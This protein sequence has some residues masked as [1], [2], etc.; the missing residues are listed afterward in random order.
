MR[1][2]WMIRVISMT[3]LIRH[4]ATGPA[5]IEVG[6]QTIAVCQCGLSRNKPFCDG[7]H[8]KT[9]GE[10]HGKLYIY[11]AAQS[12]ITIEDM[13]PTPAKKFTPGR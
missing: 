1:A 12:R 8:E 3:R 2:K 13:F 5:L 7:S 9:R 10:D 4:D 6:G 11:D